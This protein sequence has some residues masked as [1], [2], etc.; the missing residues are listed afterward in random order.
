MDMEK[1]L[2]SRNHICINRL[3]GYKTENSKLLIVYYHN[4]LGIKRFFMFQSIE[5]KKKCTKKY[6]LIM[7]NNFASFLTYRFAIDVPRQIT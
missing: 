2:V 6:I 4:T 1:F 5:L 7:R 3:V